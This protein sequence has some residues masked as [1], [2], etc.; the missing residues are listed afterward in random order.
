MLP[1]GGG[2]LAL[3]I[4]TI[5]VPDVPT[6]SASV[7]CGTVS[8]CWNIASNVTF[9]GKLYLNHYD[10]L[11]AGGI[12][13]SGSW[14]LE[15]REEH[16]LHLMYP[17]QSLTWRIYT[18]CPPRLE[19]LS[20]GNVTGTRDLGLD[21]GQNLLFRSKSK[22]GC[23]GE[24]LYL[25]R[26]NVLLLT[27][28]SVD[29]FPLKMD[30]TPT[31][32]SLSLDFGVC[33]LKDHLCTLQ[34]SDVEGN[35]MQQMFV[36]DSKLEITGLTP[37]KSYIV[38]LNIMDHGVCA[39]TITDSL[40]AT[41]LDL[42]MSSSSSLT[43]YWEKPALGHVH[44]FRLDVA[45]LGQAG[46]VAASQLRSYSLTQSGTAFLIQGLPACRKV[47]V[48]LASMCEGAT[49]T[50][51]ARVSLVAITAP[52]KFVKLAQTAAAADG[53]KVSW[54]IWGDPSEV[55]FQVYRN[56]SLPLTLQQAE[57]ACTGLEPC[58]RETFTLE[59]VCRN[60]VVADRGTI[61]VVT[62]P[63]KITELI[64]KQTVDGGFFSWRSPPA[65]HGTL[66]VVNN[67]SVA[68]TRRSYYQVSGLSAC[69]RYLYTF[70]ASCGQWMSEGTSW[71]AATGCPTEAQPSD[72]RRIITLPETLHVSIHFPWRFED[73]MD[74][75]SS[76]TYLKLA[77]IASSKIGQLF[78]Q[79]GTFTR[80]EVEM[81]YLAESGDAVEMNMAAQI[82]LG[83]S[84]ANLRQLLS[85]LQY[86]NV[87][88]EGDALFWND[89]DEC[90]SAENDCPEVA[91]CINTFDSFTCVCHQG[92]YDSDQSRV[93]RDQG[94]FANCGM[95]SMKITVSREFL[96][97]QL[98]T[99]LDL[100]LNDGECGVEEDTDFYLFTVTKTK[101]YC[102][103]QLLMNETHQIF[104][105]VIVNEHHSESPIIREPP[106]TL[107]VICAY[108]RSSSAKMPMDVIPQIRMFEPIVGYNED[109]LQ[110]AL[111][112]YKDDTFSPDA[113]YEKAPTIQLND[114]LYLEVGPSVAGSAGMPFITQVTSCWAT[115]LADSLGRNAFYFLRDGCPVDETFRWHSA[116]GMNNSTR[117]AIKMFHFTEMEKHPVYLHCQTKVCNVEARADCLT[118]CPS[119]QI[120]KKQE[121][122]IEAV[123]PEPGTGMVSTGPI[124]LHDSPRQP[125]D[126]GETTTH[127]RE[128]K[129]LLWI[130]GSVTGTSLLMVAAAVAMKVMNE[131]AQFRMAA[132]LIEGHASS[133]L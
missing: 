120:L 30:A 84:P 20:D 21:T 23:E 1:G 6:G 133:A 89:E 125:T 102:G 73:Y 92:Y 93:C 31:V 68:F 96:A 104:K 45:L 80:A 16:T 97:E 82:Q 66:V 81:L 3:L 128:V 59:A 11:K 63:D 124:V 34:L 17:A 54:S 76:R 26:I 65:S 36:Q 127:W 130:S 86:S 94:V 64:Y 72:R 103:A 129:V 7:T 70:R 83:N 18:M 58:T 51:S 109:P 55:L 114:D 49:V 118:K 14:L 85:D 106:L 90:D 121:Q 8:L 52:V 41:N 33:F 62:A 48:S 56:G 108:S 29:G 71:A 78:L 19:E 32:L 46:E 119:P 115:V 60:G 99:G 10:V 24:V 107:S 53:Y 50:E 105:H 40:P 42:V 131:R 47:H 88:V 113:V 116:N 37:C 2:S 5:L 101:A 98:S 57:F 79:S 9:T 27:V 112:L 12:R 43:I 111:F 13:R 4:A 126:P 15:Q 74:D 122:R 75:P 22:L 35:K 123:P 38:C 87:S 67:I 77:N 110:L 69:T 44:W 132:R 25:S 61:A 117:F 28:V 39:K 100:V 95:D 91:D